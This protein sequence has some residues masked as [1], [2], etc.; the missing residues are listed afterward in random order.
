MIG[1]L[2]VGRRDRDEP[3]LAGPADQWVYRKNLR[4]TPATEAPD[5]AP[6]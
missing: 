1:Y 2:R 6:T 4:A 3:L 5:R